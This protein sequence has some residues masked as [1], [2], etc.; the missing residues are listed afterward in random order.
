MHYIVLCFFPTKFMVIYFIVSI[1]K[2]TIESFIF[3]NESINKFSEMSLCQKKKKILFS[4]GK[5]E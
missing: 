5:L 2:S 1:K 4:F 3:F